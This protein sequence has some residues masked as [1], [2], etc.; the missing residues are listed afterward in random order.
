MGDEVVLGG[1]SNEVL[2][3]FGETILGKVADLIRDVG[4]D[5]KRKEKD[6]E[7]E[8]PPK[9]NSK[10][11]QKNLDFNVK[12]RNI[13]T[14]AVAFG[15]LEEAVKEVLE[16]LK[17]RNGELMLL[18]ADPSL[19]Q[20]KE[21][22]DALKAITGGTS[23]GS[24]NQ[25]D[26]TS[27]LLLSN[28]AGGSNRNGGLHM[29]KAMEVLV[30]TV[31]KDTGTQ[32]MSREASSASSVHSL[33]IMPRIVSKEG[34]SFPERLSEAIEFWG[35]ICSS[36]WVLSVIED[37]YIIQLDSRVTLPEPQGLR[38][39]VLR[40]KDF[41]FAEIERLEEEGVLE[42]SDRLPR[43]VSPLHVVEQGKKKRMILD[44]SELNKSLVPPRFKLENMKTAWPFLEN[45]NFA[46]TFDF[47]SGYHHIKIHRDSRDLLS[48]SLSNPPAAPYFSFRGLPFGL[49]TAPW[50][51]TK[52][53]KVLVRKWR[54]EGVKIFL[55]LDDGLIVGETEYE[56]A[57][58]SRRVRGDL[59]EAGVC[60]A[61]EKSFWVPDAKFTWLGYECDLVAREVRG[62]EK[63]M[64]TWQSVL[65]ELR[66]SVAPSVLDRMKF[67]GCLASFELVAGD[68]GVGRARWL[69]QTVG[70]SQKKMESKNTR[71]EKSP[72]E[73]REIEFWKAYGAELLKR[74][75]LEIEPFF[76][77][78]LFTDASARG[79]GGL[80]KDK[81]GC[82]L[83]KMSE[84]GDSNFEEQSSAWREL[85]AV[86]VASARLIGQVRGS[87]QV[88]V[89][90]QAAVSVLRRGSMKPELHALAERVWKNFES[91]GG[92]SFLHKDC[93]AKLKGTGSQMHRT[94]KRNISFP[95]ILSLDRPASTCSSTFRE[96]KGWDLLEGV[97]RSFIEELQTKV[98]SE[99]LP[100]IET[101]KAVPF[102]S[103]AMST[104]KAYKEENE[105]RNRWIAQ[106]NL[107][108]DESSLLLYLVDKAKRIGSSALTRIS[109]AYQTANES[110]STIGSSFVSDLIRSKRREEI[111]SR[112]K[113]VEVTVE[114]VSKIVELAMKEDSPAKD[115]DAPLAVLSFNVMLRAS[116][117]AEIKWSGVK[118]KD[119]M[120]EVFVER[121]KNDQMGL[122]R[123]SFFNYAPGSDTDILMCRWRLRTKGKCPYVF[124]NLDGSDK[125]SAQSISALST[126]MLK[127]IGKPGAHS[128]SKNRCIIGFKLKNENRASDR[129]NRALSRII[130]LKDCGA[131][132]HCFRRG[133]ANHMRASGHSMEEIQTRGRWRS[134][135]GLQR[136]IKDVPRAQ[137][138]SH[139]QEMLED[140]VEDDEEFEYNK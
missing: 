84:L 10:G 52:I 25:S 48:F 92:C 55:Y 87:I 58:A 123:H 78:L 39:S 34:M 106:R 94:R 13:L 138:C 120:M 68:V 116:E 73:I 103:K 64:A 11:I 82:V 1:V 121:A 114:D 126:K 3:K 28:M 37:G 89:D 101:L 113:T 107:P 9:V 61:E 62:T 29:E 44:L 69:M 100:H 57:R 83:W 128:P 30:K 134:L 35:N 86:E 93:G 140:Q 5:R 133:G 80:L 36:E 19:L 20:T 24:T 60:V 63:R 4:G 27:L 18:D 137:G 50:L 67:L 81:E 47:K 130:T 2:E 65:D 139:P 90:S 109:A 12:L 70:E 42:R 45:A 95:D 76:D 66:R 72:G 53:F 26:M 33:D 132:H 122:G 59:A 56:V 71:K 88:L 117:A 16:M 54:A 22:L 135:V 43:V 8:K 75:L 111:Q 15:Q 17:T 110:L 125:L 41:L 115:R 49:A 105:K 91:I 14:K 99:F 127:A 124:S 97:K 46:A 32:E 77:F 31:A 23:E 7:E 112:K 102:D 74:S 98:G 51:F 38:P 21:K 96:P 40:H 79:V 129:R 119:G 85:T 104:A 131:T 118:Q 108:V 6:V 136:Y